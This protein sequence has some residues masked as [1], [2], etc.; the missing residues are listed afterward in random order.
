MDNAALSRLIDII[1]TLQSAQ[2]RA[3]GAQAMTLQEMNERASTMHDAIERS[4]R[5]VHDSGNIAGSIGRS[6]EA[7]AQRTVDLSRTAL[8]A[9]ATAVEDKAGQVLLMMTEIEQIARSI[10]LLSLN[11]TIEA[12]RAGEHGRGFAIVAQEVKELSRRTMAAAKQA[13]SQMNLDDIRSSV[14]ALSEGLNQGFATLQSEVVTSLSQQATIFEEIRRDIVLVEEN[15]KVIVTSTPK[16]LERSRTVADLGVWCRDLAS[17]LT[18]DLIA[19]LIDVGETRDGARQRLDAPRRLQIEGAPLPG[20]DR[21]AAILARGKARFACDP[22]GLGISFRLTDGEPLRGLD[23]DYVRAFCDWLGV[24]PEFVEFPWDRCVDLLRIGRHRGEPPVDCMWNALPPSAAYSNIAFSRPYTQLEFNLVKRR[25]DTLV[26]GLRDLE[27][28]VLG[29]IN[30]PAALETL[31]GAGARWAANQ[32]LAGGTIRLG[33]ILPF[34][35][36]ARIPEA[37]RDGLVHAAAVDRPFGHWLANGSDS[38]WKGDLELV[39]GN[40]APTLWCYA[41]GV[42]DIPESANLLG[43]IDEFLAWFAGQPRRAAI[44]RQWQGAGMPPTRR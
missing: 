32:N 35:D 21:L 26:R 27:G 44:E 6:L 19:D 25:G 17:D 36:P 5:S 20:E 39:S 14:G 15:S 37:L 31:E 23:I 10:N 1:T 3:L 16:E 12:S 41:V 22:G 7:T 33:N 13:R 29:C 42:P 38:P 43:K 18:S 34:S 9:I 30:D 8:G 40:I 11:A 24:E 4:E 2:L 28:K